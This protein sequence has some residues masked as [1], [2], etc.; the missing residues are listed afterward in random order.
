[1]SWALAY[2]KQALKDA[3]KL[4]AAGLK[5]K[6]EELLEVLKKD[7]FQNPPAFEKLVGDLAGAYSRRINIHNRLVYEVFSKEKTIRVL[8]MWTHYQ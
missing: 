8:R 4:K 6:A 2:S 1:M 3:K 5:P 7:P